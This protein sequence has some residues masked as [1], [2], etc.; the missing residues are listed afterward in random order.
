MRLSYVNNWAKV[1]VHH[2]NR[3]SRQRRVEI[4]NMILKTII[5]TYLKPD[6]MNRSLIINNLTIFTDMNDTNEERFF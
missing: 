2:R 6:L 5:K 4:H 3:S 1:D